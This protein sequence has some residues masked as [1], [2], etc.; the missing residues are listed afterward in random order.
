MVYIN[1]TRVQFSSIAVFIKPL[2]HITS[3]RCDKW[4]CFP[5]CSFSGMIRCLFRQ[6][7]VTLSLSRKNSYG[8]SHPCCC[9]PWLMI[10]QWHLSLHWK[11]MCA[12]ALHVELTKTVTTLFIEL[13]QHHPCIWRVKRKNTKT[14]WHWNVRTDYSLRNRAE[15]VNGA[16][17]RVLKGGTAIHH[18]GMKCCGIGAYNLHCKCS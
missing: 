1:S 16:H 13:L 3:S 18:D 10:I 14:Y 11:R 12:A 17:S 2:F 8:C 7:H 6:W 15:E 9:R 5:N 4:Q